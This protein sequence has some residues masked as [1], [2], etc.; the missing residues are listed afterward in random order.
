MFSQCPMVESLVMAAGCACRYGHVYSCGSSLE[1]L[2]SGAGVGGW[3]GGRSGF[4]QHGL[5]SF[6]RLCMDRE[7]SPT[8]SPNA[9]GQE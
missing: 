9:L 4:E 1:T 3:R 7:L 5:L 6:Q 8:P 2:L